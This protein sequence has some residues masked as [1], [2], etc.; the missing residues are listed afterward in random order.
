MWTP[1]EILKFY[2]DILMEEAESEKYK[3]KTAEQVMKQGFIRKLE[4]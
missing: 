1:F 2:P 4:Y 3:D